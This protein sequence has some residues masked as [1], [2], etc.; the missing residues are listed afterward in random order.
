MKLRSFKVLGLLILLGATLSF[1]IYQGIYLQNIIRATINAISTLLLIRIIRSMLRAPNYKNK[2]LI[3]HRIKDAWGVL[4]GAKKVEKP[5]PLFSSTIGPIIAATLGGL[6]GVFLK[7]N[8]EYP[9]VKDVPPYQLDLSMLP[10]YNLTE[11][12]MGL[13]AY[14]EQENYEAAN[15]IQLEINTRKEE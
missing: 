6:A 7:N 9:N 10:K 2:A 3:S 13:E 5:K 14:L 12:K 4:T 8:V 11:L 15:L 1:T